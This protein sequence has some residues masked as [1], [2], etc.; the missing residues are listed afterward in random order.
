MKHANGTSAPALSAARCWQAV[1]RRNRW[2]DG[3]FVYGVRSTGIYCRP[4][5][6]ARKPQRKQAQF[7]A[8][9]ASAE[10]AGYRACLRC[11]PQRSGE[12]AVAAGH[13][14][15]MCQY[16]DAHITERL[17]LGYLALVFNLPVRQLAKMF[18]QVAG[19]TPQQYQAA[20]RLNQFKGAVR[21]GAQITT[22][23]HAAGFSSSSRL[24]SASFGLTP[25]SYASGAAGQRIWQRVARCYLG[26]VLVAATERGV[27]AV[28]LGASR[29]ALLRRLRAEF[30]Q[31][32]LLP[33]DA[34]LRQWVAAI[35]RDLTGRGPVAAL[36]L[37]VRASVFQAQVW[38]ALQTIPS[39]ETR[40]YQQVAAGIG[41]PRAVRAVAQACAANPVAL[42]VP[43]HRVVR[44][45]GALAGYRWGVARKQALLLREQRRKTQRK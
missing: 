1:L 9:A 17:T 31:A 8:L 39:G 34:R 27:C 36:P 6:A 29:S 38:R 33:G 20:A 45:G 43:C 24:Y 16:I 41:R 15:E 21:S 37:D 2:F 3:V 44:A 25:R 14:L 32:H 35:L 28:E 10:R 13:V 22:A 19:L 23:M 30:P 5:C 26:Y 18:R 7:F 12:D 40:T 4:S 11:H 42:L